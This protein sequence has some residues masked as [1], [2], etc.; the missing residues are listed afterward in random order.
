MLTTITLIITVA[1]IAVAAAWFRL[2][3]KFADANEK[4]IKFQ[5]LQQ[6][7]AEQLNAAKLAADKLEAENKQLNAANIELSR[8]NAKLSEQIRVT[9]A[10][11]EELKKEQENL[12]SQSQLVFRDLAH[13]IFSE[14]ANVFKA[15][16]EQ[17]MG[18]IL[19]PFA[20][21]LD[22]LKK[23]IDDYQ[24]TQLEYGASLQQQIK[25]LAM[26]NDN[27]GKEAQDLTKAL[28]GDSKV[29]GDWG[30]MI[31]AR[32]LEL[33]GLRK[34]VNYA[35]QVTQVDGMQ[36]TGSNGSSLR[37]DVVLFLPDKKNLIVDSKVSL[38]AYSNYVGASGVDEQMPLLKK[39]VESVKKHIMELAD[40][41]YQT[42][43]PNSADFVMM[44]IPNEAAYLLAME[45][46]HSL[47]EEAYKHHVIIVSPT[48]LIAV[49]KLV[50]QLWSREMQ[51]KNAQ[52][53]ADEAGKMLDKFSKFIE[54]LEAIH[55]NLDNAQK[56]YDA[57]LNKLSTGKGNLINRAHKL[58]ELGAKNTKP[59]PDSDSNSENLLP[60]Q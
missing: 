13:Q 44:F 28:K 54:D 60:P 24:K 6:A 12:K 42:I 31:L 2:N 17:R 18:E 46:D 32:I 52:Q 25:D 59:L 30:E 1:L 41:R 50:S 48:H 4:S 8:T 20:N 7:T 15:N 14:Q 16:N 56:A 40:K 58:K 57:A 35:V 37:P 47:W 23:A 9:E 51:S 5:S 21:N 45:N 29:Q 10:K 33:S 19:S 36:I 39:H 3:G 38:T 11:Q 22:K 43:V 55:K 27:L 49:V 53:I 26:V 34:D